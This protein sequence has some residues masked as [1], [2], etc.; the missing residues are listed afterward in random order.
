MGSESHNHPKATTL[1]LGNPE[2]MAARM[3]DEFRE[4][5]YDGKFSSTVEGA[6]EL[7]VAQHFDALIIGGG[8]THAN[9]ARN[10]Q[11]IV[12]GLGATVLERKLTVGSAMERFDS[13]WALSDE[14]VKRSLEGILAGLSDLAQQ[15]VAA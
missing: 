2:H 11:N 3:I 13:E 10:D 9:A 14:M 1:I 15:A 6:I 4:A 12:S 7:A 8:V 5:G